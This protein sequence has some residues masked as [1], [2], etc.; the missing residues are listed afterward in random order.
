MISAARA[1]IPEKAKIG[2]ANF[3][4][5]AEEISVSPLSDNLALSHARRMPGE[6][7]KEVQNLEKK[8]GSNC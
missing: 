7:L 6:L 5:L 8:R 3:R 4:V 1:M 2:A